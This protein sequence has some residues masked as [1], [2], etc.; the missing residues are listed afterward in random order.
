M[1][2]F[3]RTQGKKNSE[4]GTED[5]G[6]RSGN[7]ETRWYPDKRVQKVGGQCVCV[8]VYGCDTTSEMMRRRGKRN[9]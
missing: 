8:C 5:E 7:V 1:Y 3:H 2:L 4:K 6:N 9:D